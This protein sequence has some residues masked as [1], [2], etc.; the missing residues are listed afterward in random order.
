MF[1]LQEHNGETAGSLRAWYAVISPAGYRKTRVDARDVRFA[2][3]NRWDSDQVRD[4]AE[5]QFGQKRAPLRTGYSH[6]GQGCIFG[7]GCAGRWSVGGETGIGS[8]VA[9]DC[10]VSDGVGEDRG[11]GARAVA[12]RAREIRTGAA[13]GAVVSGASATGAAGAAGAGCCAKNGV[14]FVEA[15]I[16]GTRGKRGA[17]GMRSDMGVGMGTMGRA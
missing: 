17:A 1:R 14:R 4:W 8:F 12:T 9:A 7:P 13:E 5:P 2:D 6:T 11:S 16:S 3:T 10:S 15:D